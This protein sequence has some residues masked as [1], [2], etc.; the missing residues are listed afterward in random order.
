MKQLDRSFYEHDTLTVA[1]SLIGYRLHFNQF[2][3]FITETEAYIASYSTKLTQ[4]TAAMSGPA[5]TSYV[6]LIYGM[7]HCLN[8]VTEKEGIPASVLIRGVYCSNTNRH[9][10]GPGKL[11]NTWGITR[12]HNS[13]DTCNS[14]DFYTTPGLQ[15]SSILTTPRIGIKVG[16]E[17]PWRFVMTPN[18]IKQQALNDLNHN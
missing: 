10:D 4:R 6:Y 13:I 17:L 15:P 9:L 2:S 12:E 1:R 7:Y 16:T 14:S 5:G 8:I 11:C 3:G 18:D